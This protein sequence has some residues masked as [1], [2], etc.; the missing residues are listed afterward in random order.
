[1]NTSNWQRWFKLIK[2]DDKD[3]YNV[4]KISI[5][6]KCS[7]ERRFSRGTQSSIRPTTHYRLQTHIHISGQIEIFCR[8]TEDSEAGS[9]ASY[10]KHCI[11]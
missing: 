2:S 5:S 9:T 8:G 3:I 1:M 11:S 6:D 4:T 7:T 10:S